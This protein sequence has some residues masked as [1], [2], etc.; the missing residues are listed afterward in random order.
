MLYA[1][2]I[3]QKGQVVVPK[4]IRK[5]LKIKPSTVFSVYLDGGA[6]VMNPVP[7]TNEVFGMFKAKKIITKASIKDSFRNHIEKKFNSK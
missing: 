5:K 7:D 6:I 3:S 2:T 1:T 4:D